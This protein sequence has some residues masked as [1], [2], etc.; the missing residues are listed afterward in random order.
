VGERYQ[1][2]FHLLVKR[3]GKLAVE[4]LRPTNFV[5]MTGEAEKRRQFRPDPSKPQI[6]NGDFEEA[7]GDPEEPT[8]WYYQRQL[9]LVNDPK[10]P[11][12]KR[13]AKFVNQRPDARCQAL[14][15]FA[16]DGRQVKGLQV[17]LWVRGQ[18]IRPIGR[19][20]QPL[21]G[22][23]F[24]DENRALVGEEIVGPWRGT[25]PWQRQA[26]AIRVPL[27]AREAV[28]RIGLFGAT[29]ELSLDAIEVA[30]AGKP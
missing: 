25:F 22:I 24:Y 9:E 10:A 26:A 4:A 1:Q 19:E 23:L 21:L 15:G 16:V 5:P 20:G 18:D 2:V 27:K 8:G 11:S 17:S 12:G 3:D 28:I 30:P 29:G 7:A 14:Q 13:Y 6:Q